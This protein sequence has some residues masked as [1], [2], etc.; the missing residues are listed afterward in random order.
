MSAVAKIACAV[1]L[2][3]AAG[4]VP[5]QQYHEYLPGAGTKEID[6][7]ASINFKPTDSQ[8]LAARLG[9]FMERSLEVGVD[10]AYNRVKT[11]TVDDS[12]GV[13]G[14]ANLHFPGSSPLLPY[15]GVFAG[16]SDARDGDNNIS[17]GLQGGAKYFFNRNVAGFAEFRWRNAQFGSEQTGLFTGL[18]IFFK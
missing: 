16:V 14:F 18:S 10:V 11:T 4:S 15:V 17:Y 2:L 13:G 7:S 6:F 12:W 5:A 3:V 1:G 9:Y 8:N